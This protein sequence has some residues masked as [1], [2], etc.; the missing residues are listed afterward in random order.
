MPSVSYMGSQ[1][2]ILEYCYFLVVF[3]VFHDH[4]YLLMRCKHYPDC[5][6]RGRCCMDK[7]NAF[8]SHDI[9]ESV[10]AAKMFGK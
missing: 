4:F 9:R 1:Y 10:S 2:E 3:V 5:C 7:S 6:G 8:V